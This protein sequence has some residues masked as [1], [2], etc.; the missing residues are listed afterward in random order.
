MKSELLMS[1]IAARPKRLSAATKMMH[2][3]TI[4]SVA[5]DRNSPMLPSS[6]SWNPC[7]RNGLMPNHWGTQMPQNC[8]STMPKKKVGMARPK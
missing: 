2:R 3:V 1:S 7:T 8:W 4:G 6:N 5:Y